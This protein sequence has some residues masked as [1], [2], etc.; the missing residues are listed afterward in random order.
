MDAFPFNYIERNFYECTAD[1][2]HSVNNVAN[3]IELNLFPE[4]TNDR[5]LLSNDDT[6]PGENYFID[7][8][9]LVEISDMLPQLPV[10]ISWPYRK[11]NRKPTQIMSFIYLDVSLC[12][13]LEVRTRDEEWDC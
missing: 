7:I 8:A 3:D 2:I 10:S 6:D 11:L 9:K 13:C 5:G 1:C 4:E 12:P